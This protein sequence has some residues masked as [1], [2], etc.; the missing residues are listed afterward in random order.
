MFKSAVIATA[1]A[2]VAAA[3]AAAYAPQVSLGELGARAQVAAIAPLQMQF[4]CASNPQECRTGGKSQVRMSSDLLAVLQQVNS[5][6]N[7]TMVPR[8]DGTDRWTVGAT[9]GDCEDYVL[10]KRRMLIRNGVSAGSL[11]IAY[12]KTRAGAPHAVL[13]VRTSQGDLVL[14]NLSNT[15]KTLAQSG[16]RI[17]SMSSSDPTRWTAG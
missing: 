12:T 10:N 2:L 8:A 16:Y 3:P 7:R 5:H 13:V 6:V 9:A 15:V 17:R 14:D 11:R 4:F 1:F